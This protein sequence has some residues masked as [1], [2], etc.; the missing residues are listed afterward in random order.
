[1]NLSR[2]WVIYLSLQ[3]IHKSFKLF[4][5][6]NLFYICRRF[7]KFFFLFICFYFVFFFFWYDFTFICFSKNRIPI[8]LNPITLL[9]WLRLYL[10][11][12]TN[13]CFIIDR[14]EIFLL[15]YKLGRNIDWLHYHLHLIISVWINLEV[16]F[17]CFS[18]LHLSD[19]F[20]NWSLNDIL[21]L[22]KF[23]F[24]AIFYF[25]R[26]VVDM[27][28]DILIAAFGETLESLQEVCVS[29]L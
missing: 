9:T 5:F 22:L 28:I 18:S 25:F 6:K 7:V 11:L 27:A 21:C 10:L 20:L 3:I 4:L 12:N 26:L 15:F 13:F 14:L 24:E 19:I 2:I 29:S 1:M 17:V 16:L 23:I 8:I